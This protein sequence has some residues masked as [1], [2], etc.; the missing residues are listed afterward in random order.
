MVMIACDTHSAHYRVNT[1]AAAH[2]RSFGRRAYRAGAALDSP[3]MGYLVRAERV[4]SRPL[5]AI[6]TTTTHRRLGADIL[7]LLDVIWPLL[8]EQN[9]RTGHNVVMYRGSDGGGL[10]VDVGVEVFSE[11]AARGDVR[12]TS[13]PSGEVATTAHHGEYSELAPAYAALERM[14]RDTG[15]RPAGVS[16]EVYGDWDDDP[17]RRRTDVFFLLDPEPAG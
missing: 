7:R 1:A 5:A 8:R 6:S 11:F 2:Y 14:C 15:R 16:W 17:T 12:P 9:V 4:P 3:A 13:T 10:R